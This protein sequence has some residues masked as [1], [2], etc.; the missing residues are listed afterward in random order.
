MS[1]AH[2]IITKIHRICAGLLLLTMIPAAY[3]SFQG[4]KESVFVYLP[5]LFLFPLIVTGTYQLVLPWVRKARARRM[6]QGPSS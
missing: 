4:D 2:R 3:V 1:T 6:S 5:L